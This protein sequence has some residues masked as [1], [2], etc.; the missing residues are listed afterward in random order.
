MWSR[1]N[2]GEPRGSEG[3][4]LLEVLVAA[5][6]AAVLLAVV[7]RAYSSVWGGIGDVREET[8]AMLVARAVIEASAS[9]A[10]L[11]AGTQEGMSGRYVWTVSVANTEVQAAISDPIRTQPSQTKSDGERQG[12][13][14]ANSAS[15]PRQEEERQAPIWTLFR[16]AIAVHAPNGRRTTIET[17]RLSRPAR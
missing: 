15:A 11:T 4:I 1:R 16:I 13:N 5:A 14:Q 9:R 10:N 2:R 7:M 6:V 8:E 12:E 17:Y 3:F